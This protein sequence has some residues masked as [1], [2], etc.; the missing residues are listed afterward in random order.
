M[1]TIDT[2]KTSFSTFAEVAAC[3]TVHA[4]QRGEAI[5]RNARSGALLADFRRM[6]DGT[7]SVA[8]VGAGK[9]MVEEWAR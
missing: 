2:T 1:F 8:A 9:A 7:V 5:V 4:R 3:A 6:D